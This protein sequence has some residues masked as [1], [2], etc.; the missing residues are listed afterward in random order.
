MSYAEASVIL[1]NK[2]IPSWMRTVLDDQRCSGGEQIRYRARLIT[3]KD[4]NPI[5]V[6][7]CVESPDL[8]LVGLRNIVFVPVGKPR[9][10]TLTV[11]EE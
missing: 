8:G 3:D 5:A 2:V 9:T 7:I 11:K 4:F 6:E 10:Y 1:A